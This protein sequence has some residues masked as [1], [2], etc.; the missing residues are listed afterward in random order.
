MD[1]PHAVQKEASVIGVGDIV[2][3]E[4]QRSK[5]Y[6]AHIVLAIERDY[7]AMEPKYWIGNIEGRINGWCFREHIFGILVEV[8]VMWEGRYYTR[9]FPKDVF[10]EV[11]GLVKD[12]RWSRVARGLCDPWTSVCHRQFVQCGAL[13]SGLGAWCA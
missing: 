11:K 5:Q 12:F 7:H 13:L 10:E 8:Q 2:F 9:P 3:C 1:G 4:V 6:Y